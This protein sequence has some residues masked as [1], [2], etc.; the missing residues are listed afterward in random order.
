MSTNAPLLYLEVNLGKNQQEKLI[1]FEGD[2]AETI[3]NAFSNHHGLTP[4]K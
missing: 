4:E 3:V 2:D 1:L